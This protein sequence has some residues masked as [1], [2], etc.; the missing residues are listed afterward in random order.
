[1]DVIVFLQLEVEAARMMWVNNNVESGQ[2]LLP[3]G[4]LLLWTKCPIRRAN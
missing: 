2:A 1:M 4:S 3:E